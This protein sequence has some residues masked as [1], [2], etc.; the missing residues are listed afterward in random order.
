MTRTAR[1]VLLVAALLAGCDS[2]T[3]PLQSPPDCWAQA[4]QHDPRYL[5]T[6]IDSSSTSGIRVCYTHTVIRVTVP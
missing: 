5:P 2:P 3:A 6:T 4:R 1:S